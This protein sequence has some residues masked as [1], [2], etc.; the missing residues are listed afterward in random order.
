MSVA[1]SALVCVERTP[2]SAAVDLVSIRHKVQMGL[3]QGHNEN[4]DFKSASSSNEFSVSAFSRAR[5]PAPHRCG[6]VGRCPHKIKATFRNERGLFRFGLCG[7]DAL[8]RCR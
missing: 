7:A 5:A 3:W 1:F 2:S 4:D 8:V 6:R